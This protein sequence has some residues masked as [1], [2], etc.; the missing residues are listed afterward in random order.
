VR[1]YLANPPGSKDSKGTR[2]LAGARGTAVCAG[3]R[4]SSHVGWVIVDDDVMDDALVDDDRYDQDG[5]GLLDAPVDALVT[6]T[7][8]VELV[9]PTPA[10]KAR[11]RPTKKPT[12]DPV[13]EQGAPPS[14]AA[15]LALYRRYRP[16]TFAEVIGQEHVTEPLKRALDANKVNHAYL[17]SGP[18]GCGKT[19][20]ARILARC[21]NCEQGPT[22]TP[23]GV[24]QSCRDLATGGP[25]SIDVIE[26]DAATHGLVDDARDLRERAFF[27]PVRSRYKVYIIDEAHMVTTQGFNALL[28]LV[29]E[30]PPH[31]KFIFATTEP[32][33]VIGTIKSRTH[34]Y[35]FRLVPPKVLQSFLDK[36]CEEEGV[37]TEPGVLPLVVRAG[38]G[39]VR[40][41]LSVLDQLL[42][43][44]GPNGVTYADT[45]ALLGYTPD[46]LLDETV[47]AMAAHDGPGVFGAI[48]RVIESG[49]DPRHFAADLLQRLRD[50]L[51]V[52][53]VPDAIS[54]GLLDVAADQGERLKAQAERW[55]QARL[56]YAADVIAKGLTG[57]RGTTSPRLHLELMCAKVML[58]DQDVAALADRLDKVERRL[59]GG[60]APDRAPIAPRQAQ[61]P[62][63]RETRGVETTPGPAP[64]GFDPGRSAPSPNQR[65]TPPSGRPR[66]D[67]DDERPP[68]PR[69][70][71]RP[72]ASTGP[73]SAP[74]RQLSSSKPDPAEDTRPP[75]STGPTTA[76]AFG[77]NELRQAWPAVM[78]KVAQARRFSWIL[79]SQNAQPVEARDG[80]LTLGFSNAGARDSFMSGSQQILGDAL[81]SVTGLRWRITPILTGPDAAARQQR[82]AGAQAPARAPQPEASRPAPAE[83]P[84]R[85]DSPPPST[86]QAAPDVDAISL[87][88]DDLDDDIDPTELLST[89][90]GAELIAEE[91]DD[92]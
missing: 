90:L 85:F 19:S 31:V 42:G 5:P 17:F 26:L 13:V 24:C 91:S 69:T 18:R 27:Q 81:A 88:D 41:A 54:S 92:V 45:T 75:V 14:G 71:Q 35:P 48:D 53:S 34:H 4:Q 76:G 29:E 46:A 80:N 60:P 39:S 79:L 43:G 70:E 47:D 7:S 56:T 83:A 9:A 8:V 50:V 82:P 52:A 11:P 61:E 37:A 20:S 63:A 74:D 23:C 84:A 64:A 22:S 21:L 89:A 1:R 2:A 40:D 66:F 77:L 78:E 33:K 68:A 16:D 10:S 25:G 36:I 6:E 30:P 73:T 3:K 32:D 67:T 58:P 49:Q 87:D 62:Q 59:A 86:D 28:K 72:P 57:M 55:G 51:I 65:D 44:A 15:P 38:A 12:S